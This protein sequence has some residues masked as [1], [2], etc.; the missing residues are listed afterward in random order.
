M[1]KN[2]LSKA[3]DAKQDEFY[4]QLPDVE[5]ELTHYRDHFFG[6]IIYLNCD[7]PDWSSFGL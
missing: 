2:V 4:T 3:K 6:K 1:A 5:K 7:D